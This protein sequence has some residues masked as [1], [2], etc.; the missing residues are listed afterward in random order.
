MDFMILSIKVVNLM[1]LLP[2]ATDKI[3]ILYS[4]RGRVV[5]LHNPGKSSR[6]I[7]TKFH[8]HIRIVVHKI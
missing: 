2:P 6:K 5:N 4:D 8:V 1:R 3:P 7:L